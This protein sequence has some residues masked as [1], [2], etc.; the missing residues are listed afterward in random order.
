MR[1]KKDNFTYSQLTLNYISTKA[2]TL[3][4]NMPKLQVAAVRNFLEL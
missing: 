1:L 2:L 4:S 3:S